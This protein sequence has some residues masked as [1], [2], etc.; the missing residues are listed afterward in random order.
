MKEFWMTAWR[1]TP[2][3]NDLLGLH[4]AA[5]ARLRDE[6]YYLVKVAAQEFDIPIQNRGERREVHIVSY[7]IQLADEDN[8]KGGMK[9]VFD[10]LVNGNYLSDDDPA[11]IKQTIEQI[12]VKRR[13]DQRTRICLRIP[14]TGDPTDP[15][16][17]IS[18]RS[19]L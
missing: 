16:K 9:P 6:W 7:R 3:N 4:W 19:V 5:R 15:G 13:K 1:L 12:E 2:T 14:E 18:R 17:S 11:S 10:A 8:L